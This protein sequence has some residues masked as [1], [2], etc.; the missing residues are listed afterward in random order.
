MQKC[1]TCG[2]ICRTATRVCTSVSGWV[3]CT[4]CWPGTE[5]GA[6]PDQL[7]FWCKPLCYCPLHNSW[8]LK[9]L[10]APAW[11][12]RNRVSWLL[13]LTSILS[14]HKCP[15][16]A[17]P[18]VVAELV[19]ILFALVGTD[20]KLQVV[21]SQHLLCNIRAPVAAPTSHLI[22]NASVLGHGITPQQ[23]HYLSESFRP[24]IE[25]WYAGWHF[26]I[27]KTEYV[28]KVS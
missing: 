20:E 26:F 23:V 22:G 19:A 28:E 24:W 13:T 1:L 17:H 3:L 21:S 7:P 25:W 12:R 16:C 15:L 10:W 11:E 8:R 6:E 5:W 18:A 14:S 9:I 4:S 2:F 27:R